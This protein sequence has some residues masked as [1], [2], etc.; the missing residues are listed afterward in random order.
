STVAPITRTEAVVSVSSHPEAEVRPGLLLLRPDQPVLFANASWVRDRVL[1]SVEQAEP[2]PRVVVLDLEG[3]H[4]LD[5]SGLEAIEA[6]RRDLSQ[7]AVEL[8]PSNLH[9][10][11]QDLLD[12]AGV[13]G[14]I[15][16]T[17]IF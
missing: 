15:G 9:G 10:P 11:A 16:E 3:S 5:V 8:W 4:D 14:G 12:R 7:R 6:I 13:V 1:E 2:Q 17:H